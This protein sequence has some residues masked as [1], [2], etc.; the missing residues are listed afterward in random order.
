MHFPGNFEKILDELIVEGI[1]IADDSKDNFYKSIVV[2]DQT[3]GITIRMDG[4]G[5]YNDYPVGCKLYI[6]LKDLWLGDYAKI[7]QLGAGVDR[8]DSL[9][10][11]LAGIP[12][13]LF[14]RFLVKSGLQQT[15]TPIIVSAD[16]LHDTL[17][18]RLV[19]LKA[20]EF[21]P[22]DTGKPYADAINKISVNSMIR[23]CSGASVYL[24]TSGFANFAALKTPRGN[25]SII[26]VYSVFGTA[27]QLLIRDTSDVQMDGLRCTGSGSKLLLHEDFETTIPNSDINVTN[28]KNIA[29]A[30]GKVFL[31]KTASGNKY[32]EI[33]AFATGQT[34]IIS[35]LITPPVNLN[36][37]ANEVLSFQTKDG[38]DNGGVL[39]VYTSTNYD[40]GSTPWKA[41]WTQLKT[42]I[43]KGAVSGIAG[44]WV[45]SGNISLSSLSGTVYIAFRYDGA[46]PASAFDKRTTSFQLD[47]VRIVGN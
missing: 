40:G 5:L 38:F 11:E 37:S 6:K 24:R 20:V 19:M 15:V 17:Q 34:S 3:G 9:Y 46:D 25:G 8:S 21:A 42:T 36:N 12:V 35:W 4:F 43:S 16:Q 26:A 32:S 23:S 45:S 10:P 28:W 1:V 18:S 22:A 14:G 29:E 41:K 33:S 44:D 30:G 7:I 13:P 31:G 27:K 39:Q 2:Q 47:N